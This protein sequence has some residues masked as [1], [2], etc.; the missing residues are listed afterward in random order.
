MKSKLISLVLSVAFIVIIT[1]LRFY[2]A[3]SILFECWKYFFVIPLVYSLGKTFVS[4]PISRNKVLL[5]S[6]IGV[7]ISILLVRNDDILTILYKIIATI[8]GAVIIY[9]I[10]CFLKN[11]LGWN[12]LAKRMQL[13]FFLF[14]YL[15]LEFF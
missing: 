4:N 13:Y 11:K 15:C 8:L 6:T 1:L 9:L 3:N 7:L 5:F 2:P 10:T 12:I 14:Y